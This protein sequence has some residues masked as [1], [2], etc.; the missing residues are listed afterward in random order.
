[1]KKVWYDLD[2]K[3]KDI[4]TTALDV[5][6]VPHHEVKHETELNW[7]NTVVTYDVVTDLS[8]EKKNGKSP[9][10]FVIEKV[11]LALQ[12]EKDFHGRS[13]TE[14]DKKRDKERAE[15]RE[16]SLEDKKELQH[17]N[18][19][20][21]KKKDEQLLKALEHTDKIC[22]RSQ[23]KV[24]SISEF[25]QENKKP[26]FWKNLLNKLFL[27]KEVQDKQEESKPLE[28]QKD[29]STWEDLPA[30]DEMNILN[31]LIGTLLPA[32]TGI[33]MGKRVA[34]EELPYQIQ[35]DLSAKYPIEMLKSDDCYIFQ[36]DEGRFQVVLMKKGE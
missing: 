36:C 31:G 10:D 35:S 2:E 3:T 12:T 13:F 17:R 29:L 9:Y 32:M 33:G 15:L 18:V 11:N 4:I 6:C 21:Q 28:N 8:I 25:V 20:A 26:S 1:M 7:F 14:E 23:D 22:E 34:F 5:W 19:M 27:K 24:E 30:M 16:K